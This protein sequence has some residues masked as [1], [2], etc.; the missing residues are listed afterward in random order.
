MIAT[1][2][3]R[4]FGME[5][6][7]QMRCVPVARPLDIGL[8]ARLMNELR[9]NRDGWREEDAER[10][11]RRTYY[12]VLLA[13]RTLRPFLHP[14][15]DDAT[16]ER[17]LS[18]GRYNVAAIC[19]PGNRLEFNLMRIHSAGD[20][21]VGVWLE[22]SPHRGSSRHSSIALAVLEAWL[23]CV[24]SLTAE[25]QEGEGGNLREGRVRLLKKPGSRCASPFDDSHPFERASRTLH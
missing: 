21:E 14:L 15:V 10:L 11:V 19:L 5:K 22:N 4:Q 17:M 7:L 20:Y 8:W 25:M 23:D 16:F 12:L 9:D 24:I 2:T 18:T 1:E 13:P 6:D 3:E